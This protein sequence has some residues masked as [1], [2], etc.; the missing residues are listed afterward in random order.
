ML[1][2]D[3][4]SSPFTL[5]FC[6]LTL[7]QNLTVTSAA[8]CFILWIPGQKLRKF[9]K[10]LQHI[11]FFCYKC[12][13][14]KSY[15]MQGNIREFLDQRVFFSLSIIGIF[16]KKGHI[17]FSNRITLRAIGGQGQQFTPLYIPNTN[18]KIVSE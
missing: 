1:L 17:I 5:A 8:V 2:K 10:Y 12:P 11:V 9:K 14:E 16:N 13:L 18:N 6:K 3:F 15:F 4:I 7:A